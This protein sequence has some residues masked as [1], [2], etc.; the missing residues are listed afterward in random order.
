[1]TDLENIA[2]AIQAELRRQDV[3][4]PLPPEEPDPSKLM[5]CTGQAADLPGVVRAVLQAILVP[6][7][8]MVAAGAIGSGEDSADVARGAWQA[9]IGVM[10]GF[11]PIQYL[12]FSHP[13]WTNEQTAA[14][15]ARADEIA[16]EE[17]VLMYPENQRTEAM[18]L[19]IATTHFRQMAFP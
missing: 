17:L 2:R 15:W 18:R 13:R 5:L 16:A 7:A 12:N 4:Y 6:S 3:L 19:Q 1:M 11:A 14:M 10:L 9:M 8:E